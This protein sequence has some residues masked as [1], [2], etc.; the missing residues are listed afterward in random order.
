MGIR[1]ITL[2][3]IAAAVML[4]PAIA[5]AANLLTDEQTPASSGALQNPSLAV[6]P[7]TPTRVALA[8]ANVPNAT[9]ARAT[10]W[11]TAS[12]TW[13]STVVDPQSGLEGPAI[14]WGAGADVYAAATH[15]IGGACTASSSLA[16]SISNNA[17]MTFGAPVPFVSNST[18]DIA[19]GTA[20]AYDA[21]NTDVYVAYAS[22]HWAAPGCVGQPTRSPAFVQVFTSAGAP[23]SLIPVGGATSRMSSP[24]ITVTALG[25]FSVAV[26][27]TSDGKNDIT[28][29]ACRVASGCGPPVV[30]ADGTAATGT[31]PAI[32]QSGGRIVVAW[33]AGDD[34]GARVR[35]ATSVNGG[36]S[37]GQSVPIEP[38]TAT[39]SAPQLAA[40]ANGR[41]DER[42]WQHLLSEHRR[43]SVLSRNSS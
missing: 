16:L 26:H 30:V 23:K 40:T 36:A 3:A 7:A 38:G 31:P 19:R 1:R 32:A 12:G 29:F 10:N 9:V 42:S 43:R 22:P 39:S 13:P 21:A 25:E 18:A 24:A 11:L 34:A 20:I 5:A 33:Q 41:V 6:D 15:E 28:T 4:V 35:S 8:F 17:G 37:Y 14:A 2:A 27:D